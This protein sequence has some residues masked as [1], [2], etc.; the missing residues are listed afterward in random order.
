MEIEIHERIESRHLGENADA[1]EDLHLC[2][3]GTNSEF[4]YR[5][6]SIFVL[7]N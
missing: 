4:C 3:M 2:G 1:R 7:R 5:E 6:A